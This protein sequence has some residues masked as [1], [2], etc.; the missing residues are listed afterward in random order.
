MNLTSWDQG[1]KTGTSVV[2][3]GI[4]VTLGVAGSVTMGTLG[5]VGRLGVVLPVPGRVGTE[6]T[7]GVLGMVGTS[8]MDGTDGWT[9]L[10]A[11]KDAHIS[12]L[13]ITVRIAGKQVRR[14]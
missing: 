1:L 8:G 7:S 11:C 10:D 4:A 3:V 6:G 5:T 12:E 13:G 9:G 2:V 14:E